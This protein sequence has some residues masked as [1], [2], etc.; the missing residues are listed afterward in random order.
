MKPTP[1]FVP[2]VLSAGLLAFLGLWAASCSR[3]VDAAPRIITPRG[4]LT[5]EERSNID[6]FETWKDPVVFIATSNRVVTKATCQT[7][8]R[9][10]GGIPDACGKAGGATRARGKS[11]YDA[12]IRRP[13]YSVFSHNS[14]HIVH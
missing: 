4:E 9:V 11:P 6:V 2:A 7:A 8:L 1:S 12:Y 13:A 5:A 10:A 3:P 14:W